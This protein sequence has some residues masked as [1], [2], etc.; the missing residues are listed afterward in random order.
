M[1]LRTSGPY[2]FS[3]IL[4][5]AIFLLTLPLICAAQGKIAFTSNR[6]GNW[7]IYVMDSDGS[8]QTRLTNTPASDLF[9]SFSRDGSK[10]VF[11]SIRDGN[12][13]IYVMNPDGSN[14]TRLTNHPA[15]D[16]FPTFSPD[17]SKI[18]FNSNR[19]GN[20][21]L[22]SMNLDG[23][24]QT[25]ITNNAAV[26]AHPS[27]N[28]DGSK[29]VFE[30]DRHG[31]NEIYVMNPDGT[32]QIRLTNNSALD[33]DPAFSPDG[34]KIVF[35]SDRDSPLHPEIY[36]MNADGSNQTRLTYTA[37]LFN[38]YAS[39]SPDGSK[40]V[41]T[42]FRD[43]LSAG[44]IY[45]MN[46]DGTNQIPL[47]AGL[48]PD[49]RPSWS[50]RPNVA[51]TIT[52]AAGVTVSRDTNASNSSIAAVN[53]MED[54]ENALSVTVN[55]AAGATVN[56]VTVSGI[57]VDSSGNVTASIAAT[58]G[59]TDASFTLRVTDSGTLFSQATLNVAVTAETGLPVVALPPDI[60][61]NLPLNSTDTGKIVNFT[62]SATDNCDADPLVT[63]V[64]PS[65]STFPVGATTVNVTA[66]DASGN[67]AN[68]SFTV[69]VLYNF[70]GFFQPVDNLPIVNLVSAGQAIPVKF[71]LSGDK[72][73]NIFAA[74][75]PL[76]QQIAC[77]GGAPVSSVEET[78][79]AGASSLS[80]DAA[81][82][83]YIYVWK[84]EKAWKGT[85]R[86]LLVKLNDGSLHIAD[87]RFR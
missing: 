69:T 54:A 85:C 51:P 36:V 76:W 2:R 61:T 17:G 6:D 55:G 46:S 5:S 63:A 29:I 67:T 47:G 60:V 58:C 20:L 8:N 22:Y 4:F 49:E 66:T 72:G 35:A 27:F 48:G 83:R 16:Y 7:E 44:R 87:F 14:Q 71:S 11:T 1:K 70:A 56:G 34:S 10:I 13:E 41:F 12:Q 84:T 78:V 74:G 59:A 73:L 79:T 65:G 28:G 62:V 19:D 77:S 15:E 25:R 30:S 75:Y 43:P 45:V 18:V 42:S 53:D 21:E 39:F 40:I 50:V 82:D 32:N 57:A 81:T 68:G 31:N 52:A 26:D 9:Q 80:Y 23:S 24:N 3:I 37:P 38:W 86:Q 64:P 33:F